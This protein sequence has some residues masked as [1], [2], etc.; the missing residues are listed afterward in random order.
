MYAKGGAAHP[1]AAASD[2]PGLGIDWD[3]DTI[4][5]MRVDGAS[6]DVRSAP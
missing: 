5:A 3:W 6:Y 1:L 4:G 2:A